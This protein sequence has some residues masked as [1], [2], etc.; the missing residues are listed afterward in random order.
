MRLT[1]YVFAGSL[2]ELSELKIAL[3]HLLEKCPNTPV[4]EERAAASLLGLQLRKVLTAP[5]DIRRFFSDKEELKA[6]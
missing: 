3:D 2:S 4:N 5:S 6:I 1:V